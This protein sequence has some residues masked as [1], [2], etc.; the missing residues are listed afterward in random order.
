MIDIHTHILPGMDD[1]AK[2]VALSLAMLQMEY[3]QGIDTV[4][5]TPHFYRNKET[6]EQ[7]LTRRQ[8]A[9]EKL[10]CAIRKENVIVPNL[11]LGA[12]VAW[13]PNM[14]R[15]EN[16]EQLCIGKSKNMLLELPFGPWTS[17]MFEQLYDLILDLQITPIFAHLE[18]YLKYQNRSYIQKI[19]EMDMPIQ[20]SSKALL[21]WQSRRGALKIIKSASCCMLGSD[22][23]NITTRPPNLKDG[24]EVLQRRLNG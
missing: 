5:L 12:E 11:I 18:R 1:G 10:E 24:M 13:T 6:P 17:N 16:L 19:I 20:V 4:V 23:H 21:H 8:E 14:D 22:C 3:A 9:F 15:W 2:D 7:F